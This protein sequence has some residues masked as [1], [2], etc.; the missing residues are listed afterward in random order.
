MREREAMKHIF[1]EGIQGM[2][3]ETDHFSTYFYEEEAQ[4]AENFIALLE[5]KFQEIHK[6]FDFA[7]EKKKINFHFCKDAQ[8]FIDVTG[9]SQEEYQTWMVGNSNQ[10]S[11][12]IAIISPNAVTERNQEDM[13]KIA[14][15]ELVHMIFDDA[16]SMSGDDVEPW[17]AEGIAVL[18]AEQTNLDYIS[19][20]CCPEIADIAG[21]FEAFV[22]NQG[23]DYSG[24]YV[25]YFVEKYG[26]EEFLRA[27]QN[28]CKWGELIY[29][30]FEKE[31]IE[32][33]CKKVRH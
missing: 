8:E 3:K 16:T 13:E 5:R 15:H 22:E 12:T 23:Y 33:F 17:I 7:Y 29:E 24:I 6:A 21:N 20:D 1:I 9:K 25:W 14:V 32:N 28:E 2:V 26:F 27:Y 4:L 19:L 30:G 10:E 18:Y 31:A 11:H